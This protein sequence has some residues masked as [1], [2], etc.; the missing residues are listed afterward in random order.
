MISELLHAARDTKKFFA[1]YQVGWVVRNHRKQADILQGF[2]ESE[3]Q[4]EAMEERLAKL[5]ISFDSDQFIS[6]LLEQVQT[7]LLS[8]NSLL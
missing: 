1:R 7:C 8:D 5:P 4:H 6:L 2:A 3:E